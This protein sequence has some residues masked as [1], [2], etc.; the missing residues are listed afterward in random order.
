M[1]TSII[2]AGLPSMS[3][4]SVLDAFVYF[5]MVSLENIA[6]VMCT[7]IWVVGEETERERKLSIDTSALPSPQRSFDHPGVSLWHRFM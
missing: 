7:W 2:F 5:L 3:L 1:Y 4:Y 6:K